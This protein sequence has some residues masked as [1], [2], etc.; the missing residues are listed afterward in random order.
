MESTGVVQVT[1]SSSEFV[2]IVH[3]DALQSTCIDLR[4]VSE[5][6]SRTISRVATERITGRRKLTLI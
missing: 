3:L 5:Q 1:Q 2:V 4:I 6:P